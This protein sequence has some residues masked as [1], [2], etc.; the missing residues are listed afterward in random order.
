MNTKNLIKISTDVRKTILKAINRVGTGHAGSSLSTIELL[1]ALYF[2]FMKIN[3][4][5]PLDQYRDRFIL[6]KGHAAPGLYS[7]LA[8]RGYFEIEK[9]KELRQFGSAL[10]GHP[11]RGILPGVDLSTGSLGQGLSI[12]LGMAM[13]LKYQNNPAYVFCM[14]GDGE[15]Q[16]GQNWEAAMAAASFD[17]DNLTVIV[18]RNQLQNDKATESIVGLEDIVAKFEAFNWF[19]KRIDGHNFDQ[20]ILALKECK[21]SVKPSCI[22]ADTIKG[23]GVSYMENQIKWHHHPITDQELELALTELSGDMEGL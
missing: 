23:K 13:G 2:Y 15:L 22:I 14:L 1:V 6:S 7:V 17:I 21:E 18:D 20:I 8:H 9:L 10:Q 12:S 19:V 11:K 3:P 4:K 5:E 16:E